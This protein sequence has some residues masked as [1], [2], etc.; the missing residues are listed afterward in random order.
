MSENGIKHITTAPKYPAYNGFAERYRRSFKEAMKK[1]RTE[2]ENLDTK[3]SS[4]YIDSNSAIGPPLV[5][6]QEKHQ[7]S[8]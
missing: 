8:C 2:K 6:Q 3:L 5:R 1:M 4:L 7:V